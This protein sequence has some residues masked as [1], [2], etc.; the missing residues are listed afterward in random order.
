MNVKQGSFTLLQVV[1]EENTR[2]IA[3]RLCQM[4]SL[5]RKEELSKVT[6]LIR[7]KKSYAL[8]LTRLL[9]VQGSRKMSSEYVHMN[10]VTFRAINL[11]KNNE[12]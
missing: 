12:S 10:T 5:K 9:R 8:L 1:W 7:C 2:T 3:K 4:I 11:V 6:Y